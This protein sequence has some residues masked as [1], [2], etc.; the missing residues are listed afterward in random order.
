MLVDLTDQAV[1][2]AFFAVIEHFPETFFEVF[3]PAL[4]HPF[5]RLADGGGYQTHHQKKQTHPDA[6]IQNV[7]AEH[8]NSP[9]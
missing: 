4:H 6:D 8:I 7:R 1:E 2:I 9:P 3:R 5:D